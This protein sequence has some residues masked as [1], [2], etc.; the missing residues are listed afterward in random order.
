MND[1]KQQHECTVGE[2]EEEVTQ[3]RKE[4]DGGVNKV[5]K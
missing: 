5:E 4:E 3:R 1:K 2:M